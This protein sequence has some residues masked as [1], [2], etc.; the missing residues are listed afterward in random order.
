MTLD[1][2]R[3][4]ILVV[5]PDPGFLAASDKVLQGLGYEVRLAHAAGSDRPTLPRGPFNLIFYGFEEGH[6]DFE[7]LEVAQRANPGARVVVIANA[8]L[9]D[10]IA[11][12]LERNHY[13]NF[14]A[15]TGYDHILGELATTA[16][17]LF[18]GD[19]FGVQQHLDPGTEI[20]QVRVRS[21]AER[22]A[23]L[24]TVTDFASSQGIR[25]RTLRGAVDMVDEFLMNAIYD[26][27]ADEAGRP[28]YD[29]VDRRE[30][31]VLTEAQA[32]TL[33]WGCDGRYLGIGIED[34]FGR[35]TKRRVLEYLHKCFQASDGQI[36]EEPGGAGLG[37]YR[38]YRSLSSLVI[39]LEPGRRTEMIGLIDVGRSG[40]MRRRSVRSFHFFVREVA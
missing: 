32:G 5:D 31:V 28:L 38:I 4:A 35:L 23:Y 27:P 33:S 20:G 11:V 2:P 18:T 37:L 22:A 9:E 7:A 26:A 16:R 39:N 25:G 40:R 10:Y 8:K 14:I 1:A 6:P 30:D 24:Q 19:I 3:R 29:E 17:K 13:S 21:S 34:P 12:L 36:D 15:M